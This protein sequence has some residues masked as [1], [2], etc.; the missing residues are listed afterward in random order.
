M[1][2]RILTKYLIVTMA[3]EGWLVKRP[4]WWLKH[5]F[6]NGIIGLLTWVYVGITRDI[7]F[8]YC[9]AVVIPLFLMWMY[10]CGSGVIKIR[11]KQQLKIVEKIMES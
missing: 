9:S 1:R 7:F 3:I 8:Y 11:Q 2:D 10:Y 4:T 5:Q 6:C